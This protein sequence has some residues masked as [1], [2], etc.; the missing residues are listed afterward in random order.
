MTAD[1]VKF[2]D[3]TTIEGLVTNADESAYRQ[4][5]DGW[6]TGAPIMT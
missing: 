1:P 5:V 3:D 2:S 4:E 6:L